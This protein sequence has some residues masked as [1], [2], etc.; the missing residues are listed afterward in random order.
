MVTAGRYGRDGDVKAEAAHDSRT[1]ELLGFGLRPRMVRRMNA[2][3]AQLLLFTGL[4]A[5]GA[6]AEPWLVDL[7]DPADRARL[8]DAPAY[9]IDATLHRAQLDGSMVLRWT[10]RSGA[11]LD[12]LVVQTYA[13]GK[14]FNGA[15]MRVTAA[16]D[17]A[18]GLPVESYANG[19]GARIVARAPI[20]AGATV[21]WTIRWTATLSTKG[22]HHGLLAQ[23]KDGTAILH[24]WYPE[25]APR[26]DGTWLVEEVPDLGDTC[27]AEAHHLAV[28]LRVPDGSSVVCGGTITA[29]RDEDGP[30]RAVEL[31]AAGVRNLTIVVGGTWERSEQTVGKAVVRSWW[32]KGHEAGGQRAL[33]IAARAL[34]LYSRAF[35]PYAWGELEVVEADLGGPVGGVESNGLIL[36]S[37]DAYA[38]LVGTDDTWPETHFGITMMTHV[39]AHEVAHQWWQCLVG[40][41]AV[42]EPWLD[43][44]LTNWTTGWYWEQTFPGSARA[45]WQMILSGAFAGR[46]GGKFASLEHG[47][48][49]FASGSEIGAE[50]YGRGSF[51]FQALRVSMGDAAFAALLREWAGSNRFQAV[52]AAA[53]RALLER[54]LDRERTDAWW[55]LWVR[56]QG[57]SLGQ[58]VRAANAKVGR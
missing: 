31:A 23:A 58:L 16:A 53:F 5:G 29:E 9:T 8:L 24:V 37:D 11:A 30:D 56:G 34:E 47:I 27:R 20:A 7:A 36:I 4:I 13:N 45:G 55:E 22:G 32:R 26:G 44:S 25:V 38:S 52:D 6:A 41:D 19:L 51:A 46:T 48:N 3:L 17:A 49:D 35:T 39:V 40:N 14:H 1:R 42:A 2:C 28:T 12:E 43:E 33:A 57:L 18:G 10:N 50:V 15:S 54:R 21:E